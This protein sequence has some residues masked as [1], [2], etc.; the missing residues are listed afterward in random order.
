MIYIWKS[1]FCLFFGNDTGV[2]FRTLTFKK[3]FFA[4]FK[5]H[6]YLYSI[7]KG[8]TVNLKRHKF[9]WASLFV[10]AVM[11]VHDCPSR[12]KRNPFQWG[13]QTTKCR[14]G[15]IV[16][17]STFVAVYIQSK[18]FKGWGSCIH[19]ICNQ[20][21]SRN[22]KDEGWVFMRVVGG[23]IWRQLSISRVHKTELN[24]L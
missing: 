8:N 20:R 19:G 5:I 18:E 16:C 4:K 9:D 17:S 15:S 14:S 12:A 7:Y 10:G 3:G 13:S 11:V 6:C 24:Y 1:V 21:Y 2:N 22:L 23:T